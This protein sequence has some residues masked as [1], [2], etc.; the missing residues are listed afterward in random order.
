MI[1]KEEN[2][3]LNLIRLMNVSKVEPE[4]RK[5]RNDIRLEVHKD[6]VYFKTKK[7]LC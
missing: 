3:L 4:R 1:T 6:W 2:A 7:N 5:T